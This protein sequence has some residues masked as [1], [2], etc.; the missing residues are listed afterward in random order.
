MGGTFGGRKIIPEDINKPADRAGRFVEVDDVIR[1][2]EA[3]GA[4]GGCAVE[5]G[6]EAGSFGDETAESF[7]NIP[8]VAGIV[9]PVFVERRLT[10]ENRVIFWIDPKTVGR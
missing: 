7:I 4:F 6:D 8:A 2:G 5:I 1:G 9:T 10:I 3:V